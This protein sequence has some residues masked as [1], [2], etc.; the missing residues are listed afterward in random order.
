MN[1][2]PLYSNVLSEL[3]RKTPKDKLRK[4]CKKCHELGHGVTSIVCKFN[5]DRNNKL[6]QK[7]KTHILSTNCL[8][9][10]TIEDYCNELSVTL[11]ITP[12]LCKTLYNEI[13]LIDL[14]EREINITE[15][16]ECVETNTILCHDCEKPLKCI[17]ENTN[18]RW[19][20]KDLCDTCWFKY[21]EERNIIWDCIKLYKPV[22]CVICNLKQTNI[23][24]RFH[25][26][27]LNMFDKKNSICTMVNEGACLDE[28]Y[29][30]I[31]KCQ[32]LC[33]TCH[34]MVTDIENKLGFTRIKQYLTRSLNH[35][36]ITVEEY[37]EKTNHYQTLYEVKMK[38]IYK[39]IRKYYSKH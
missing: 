19:H 18:R 6:K 10:N 16:L 2:P 28:I 32:I 8:T 17:H 39:E 38:D 23:C 1:T 35:G 3:M 11:N 25:Y 22:Q 13:P 5:I 37:A 12:N 24:E 15:Y 26:D 33:L 4:V 14:L 21:T 7:I 29:A 34:H 20:D 31:D 30:E 9:N 36:D 27:H